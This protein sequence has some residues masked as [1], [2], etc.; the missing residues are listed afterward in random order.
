MGVDFGLDVD[1]GFWEK[2][3]STEIYSLQMSISV[4]SLLENRRQQYW[5]IEAKQILDLKICLCS[6]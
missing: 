1:F 5:K 4:L 6:V 3:R 2:S